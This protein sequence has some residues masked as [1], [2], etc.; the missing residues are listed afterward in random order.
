MQAKAQPTVP[1]TTTTV[2]SQNTITFG[3][4]VTDTAS[5]TSGATGSVTFYVS[6]DGVSWTQLDTEPLTANIASSNAYYPSAAGTYYFMATYSG[7]SN[8]LTSS[9]G[10]FDELLTVNQASSTTTTS[11]SSSTITLG[12]SV[13]DTATVTGVS[14]FAVPTGTVQFYASTDGGSTWNLFDTESLNVVGTATSI[15]FAPSAASATGASY[16]FYAVYS[17]DNNYAGSQSGYTDEP[18]TVNEAATTTATLLSPLG[19]ITLGGTVADTVIISTSASGTLPSATGTWTIYA[20]DNSAMTDE[21]SIGSGAV[22]GALS[23]SATTAPWTATHAGTWY[24]QAVYSGDGNYAGSMS[25]PTDEALVVNVA[26]TVSVSPNS[27]AMDVS[28]S[29][30]LTATV[31]G[32][33]SQYT[34]QWLQM[35][36]SASSYSAINDATSYSYSFATTGSTAT[37]VWSFELQVTDSAGAVI[38]SSA[39]TVTVAASPTVSIAP[40]GPVALDVGQVQAFTA[41]AI[42]GSGSLSY[43]W[44]LDGSAVGSDNSGYSYT[45]SGTSH[46]VTCK[47]T[48]SASVPVTSSASNAVTITVAASPTV[49]ISPTGPLTLDAGQ[50][51]TFTAIASGGSGT[52]SYQWYLDGAMLS[53][54]SASYLYTALAGLH[55]VTCKVTDSASTPVTSPVSNAVLVTANS[56]LI[57]PTE[58]STPSTVDQGQ[59]VSLTSTA[60]T[61]GTSPYTYQ[62]LQKAPD[63]SSY[64]AI[65]GAVSSSNSFA[66][67]SSTTTGTWSFELQVTDAAAAVTTSNPTVVTVNSDPTVTVTPTSW[68]MD[69]GQSKTFSATVLVAVRV[70]TRVISGM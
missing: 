6:T 41:T 40:V 48:D 56:A 33:T 58:T 5:V 39:A 2:L 52:L 44:Y 23:F 38:T 62:W 42:G 36:P 57:A 61:T 30:T 31:S 4:S 32:G 69:V 53:S 19:P 67:S 3:G 34:Y 17:G 46:T 43:Q 27:G 22:S 28:Q 29:M 54:N 11:L 70:L 10:A 12:G 64:S 7:D 45:A 51:Q 13:T 21:V 35:A 55:S 25:T 63:A 26:P 50:I 24:F 1:T 37:G 68:T 15:P 8:F 66:T 20:A 18:L 59:T 9:S 65:S 47:V 49:I 14:G 60:V 16:Y